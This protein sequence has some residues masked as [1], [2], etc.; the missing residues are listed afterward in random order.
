MPREVPTRPQTARG[1]GEAATASGLVLGRSSKGPRG[2]ETEGRRRSLGEERRESDGKAEGKGA[3]KPQ[4]DRAGG[5]TQH[6]GSP[7]EGR[8]KAGGLV[9]TN[10]EA[11]EAKRGPSKKEHPDKVAE[12]ARMQEESKGTQGGKQDRQP[13]RKLS[14]EKKRVETSHTEPAGA[15]GLPST[16][17]IRQK[18][19]SGHRTSADEAL[20]PRCAVSSSALASPLSS[21]SP[22][23]PAAQSPLPASSRGTTSAK[24][25]VGAPM[26]V[27]ACRPKL[28]SDKDL[29]ATLEDTEKAVSAPT[30]RGA[31]G[32]GPERETDAACRASAACGEAEKVSSDE[33]R[34]GAKALGKGG[35]KAEVKTNARGKEAKRADGGEAEGSGKTQ[36]KRERSALRPTER[37]GKVPETQGEEGERGTLSGGREEE[38]E[39]LASFTEEEKKNQSQ[40]PPAAGLR[41]LCQC[42]QGDSATEEQEED[43]VRAM[44]AMYTPV[45]ILQ[46]GF[47]SATFLAELHDPLLDFCPPSPHAPA[48][49]DRDRGNAEPAGSTDDLVLALPADFLSGKNQSV[50]PVLTR[51]LSRAGVADQGAPHP[52]AETPEVFNLRACPWLL[53]LSVSGCGFCA[54]S[55][56]ESEEEETE[57][58]DAKG[59][60]ESRNC[61][62]PSRSSP[63]LSQSPRPGAL[64]AAAGASPSTEPPASAVLDKEQTHASWTDPIPIREPFLHSSPSTTADIFPLDAQGSSGRLSPSSTLTPS[65]PVSAPSRS[66]V[67]SPSPDGTATQ[68]TRDAGATAETALSQRCQL[69]SGECDVECVRYLFRVLSETQRAF[70]AV[71]DV[72]LPRNYPAGPPYVAVGLSHAVPRTEV[73]RLLRDL[74]EEFEASKGEV[75]LYRLCL[76]LQSFMAELSST[77]CFSNLWEEMHFKE[78]QRRHL[79]LREQHLIHQSLKAR[80]G[81]LSHPFGPFA[82]RLNDERRAAPLGSS[83]TRHSYRY[84]ATPSLA[85]SVDDSGLVGSRAPGGG[86]CQADRGAQ[87]SYADLATA[88][89]A[90]PLKRAGSSRGD[91]E[92]D[93]ADSVPGSANGGQFAGRL[94]ALDRFGE[95]R[96]ENAFT[97][98][99]AVKARMRRI[100]DDRRQEPFDNDPSLQYSRSV[101]WAADDEASFYWEDEDDEEV[102]DFLDL[103]ED[104]VD[105]Q[106]SFYASPSNSRRRASHRRWISQFRRCRSAVTSQP[107]PIS[108]A[109]GLEVEPQKKSE[110]PPSLA[111]DSEVPAASQA[112]SGEKGGGDSEPGVLEKESAQALSG[113]AGVPSST[114]AGKTPEAKK[115]SDSDAGAQAGSGA[116]GSTGARDGAA[117]GDAETTAPPS[118]LSESLCVAGA[119]GREE[120]RR[121]AGSFRSLLLS[122]QRTTRYQRDFIQLD[123][124][125]SRERY[126]IALVYHIIDKHKYIVKQ[127]FIPCGPVS[128]LARL[129]PGTEAGRRRKQLQGLE[130]VE[131]ALRQVTLLCALQHPYIMRYHQ[132]WTQYHTA[133]A[134]AATSGEGGDPPNAMPVSDLGDAPESGEE[135]CIGVYVQMEF[136]ER[137]LED[138]IE[139]RTVLHWDS[140]QIWTL[141]RQTLEAL[142][143]IH[144]NRVC[145]LSLK[146]SNVFL[147]PDAY[148]Y[149]VKLG[150][151]GITSLFSIVHNVHSP[152]S[153]LYTA[154]ELLGAADRKFAS[155]TMRD[156]DKADMYSLG[157][158]FAEM[159]GRHEM[160]GRSCSRIEFLTS[161]VKERNLQQLNV[162]SAA[163]KIIKHLLSPN[164]GDR[165]SSMTLLQSSLLPPAVEE[166]LFKAFLLRL[167]T[168]VQSRSATPPLRDSSLSPAS[169][170]KTD[171]RKKNLDKGRSSL[172]STA[173]TEGLQSHTPHGAP[174]LAGEVLKIF[175]RRQFDSASATLFFSDFLVRPRTVFRMRTPFSKIWAFTSCFTVLYLHV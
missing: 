28:V 64:N 161:L 16:A 47:L 32:A 55:G 147:E 88:V 110:G 68:E 13:G 111:R 151:F 148:G 90:G 143:Y 33:Q 96:G 169:R 50:S 31:G 20:K 159:W 99:A 145:H 115:Q 24:P 102:S 162:P 172:A 23:G 51:R 61:A 160:F 165:P 66:P 5:K 142:V 105:I 109:F 119:A 167:R 26:S 62:S 19:P 38:G 4:L 132:A 118:G 152:I 154:P 34:D 18:A 134:L 22:T 87:G 84:A 137:S 60:K 80:Q 155:L 79:L 174:G 163:V 57:E 103:E 36:E 95:Q 9:E 104:Y 135:P 122:S 35:K 12:E 41:F 53:R 52:K 42:E 25:P 124:L 146:P 150:D 156:A 10:G 54:L 123:V 77:S 15:A 114:L 44:D 149:N 91:L 83:E 100:L 58:N 8:E 157:V 140:Q 30:P 43:E 3:R 89:G 65:G 21:M 170:K 11:A 29:R 75:V 175:F 127:I 130:L 128:L 14:G 136:C 73:Q 126:R 86:P 37:P 116:L 101:A 76:Q 69:C 120:R 67:S 138:E 17:G 139:K 166:D 78:R 144:R 82:G 27:S 133:A 164:P 49:P 48:L 93:L 113:Q 70:F 1:P 72:L 141:F 129:S 173:Q 46:P 158:L 56:E 59:E 153:R 97:F 125:S 121:G 45:K 108:G 2:G 81:L 98:Q 40:E 112:L 6:R 94:A 39:A 168:Q 85:D 106:S 63:E 7:E 107:S 92:R 171:P 74:R 117:A 71:V 131:S